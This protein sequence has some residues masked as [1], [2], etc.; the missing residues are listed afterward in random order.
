MA[1][2]EKQKLERQTAIEREAKLFRE[3][4]AGH[5]SQLAIGKVD[6]GSET[7]LL[8]PEGKPLAPVAVRKG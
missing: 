2:S 3:A 4:T 1:Q 7:Q 6:E 5:H 8:T